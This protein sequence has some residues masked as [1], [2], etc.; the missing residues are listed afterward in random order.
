MTT[1]ASASISAFAINDLAP[2]SVPIIGI[3]LQQRPVKEGVGGDQRDG[4]DTINSEITLLKFLKNLYPK[5]RILV[6]SNLLLHTFYHFNNLIGFFFGN[7][8]KLD[9]YSFG[10]CGFS[11]FIYIRLVS[12]RMRP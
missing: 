12:P 7:F 9:L 8:Q 10:L 2:V 4:A 3:K 5:F 6:H 11:G 1:S